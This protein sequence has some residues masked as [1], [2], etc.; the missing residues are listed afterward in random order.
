VVLGKYVAVGG[1]RCS[2]TAALYILSADF[3]DALPADQDQMPPDGNPHPMPG[4]L[5]PNMDL[6]WAH[7][8][9]R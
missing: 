2:W 6:L 9:L 8:F 4:H 1:V 7:N 3:A 5:L